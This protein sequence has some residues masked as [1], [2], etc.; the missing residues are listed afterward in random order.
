MIFTVYFHW[1]ISIIHRKTY[2]KLIYMHIEGQGHSLT[3]VPGYSDSTFSNFFS[4]ET[5]RPIETKLHRDPP[6][7]WGTK[8]WSI[9]PCHMTKMAAM[10]IYGKNILWNQKID[11]LE[12]W[13]AASGTRVLPRLFKW[14]AWIHH[15]FYDKVKCCPLAFVLEKGKTMDFSETFVVYDIK[16]S[17]CSQI[18]AY[19]K[20]YEYKVIHWPWSKSLRSI[21]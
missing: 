18:N 2:K 15:L 20:L 4:L 19:M 13:Y 16:V 3:L 12:S 11:D 1:E 7:G 21:I 17:K 8:V 6:W 9:G 10:P 5:A 14:W